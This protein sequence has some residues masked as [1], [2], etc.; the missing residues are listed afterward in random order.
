MP[1]YFALGPAIKQRIETCVDGL[2]EVYTPFSVEDMLKMNSASPSVSVIWVDERVGE[3]AGRGK[4][5]PV[6]QQWL[7]VFSIHDASA[8]LQD[9]ESI[10]EKAEPF[11]EQ[12]LEALMGWNPGIP[13]FRPLERINAGVPPGSSSGFA[14]FPFLFE[15]QMLVV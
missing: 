3:S 6:N 15:S 1:K 11:I 5:A 10:R 12:L 2:I 13:G 9:T 14:Y 8:Q 7:V 4:A